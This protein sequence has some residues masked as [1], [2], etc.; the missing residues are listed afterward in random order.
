MRTMRFVFAFAAISSLVAAFAGP[1]R[2]ERVIEYFSASFGP[3]TTLGGVALG[4]DTPFTI[5]ATFDSTSFIP[6]APGYKIYHVSTL[7]IDIAG[8]G[9]YT[10][11]GLPSTSPYVFLADSTWAGL[12]LNVVGLT[13]STQSKYF[14]VQFTHAAPSFSVAAPIS[15]VFSGYGGTLLQSL[16][17]SIALSGVTGGLVINDFDPNATPQ[18]SLTV[19]EPTSIAM[20]ATSAVAV[21]SVLYRRRRAKR[22][23]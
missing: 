9:T 6:Q 15:T 19:P 11:S 10:G 21:L 7:T 1:A 4:A 5:H 14:F 18:A 17:Y 20:G 3:T 16:P 12:N 2:T 13:N 8:H 23:A 22:N